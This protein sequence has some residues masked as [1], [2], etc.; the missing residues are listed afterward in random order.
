MTAA[1]ANRLWQAAC[2]PAE[3]AFRR[4]LADP[5]AAQTAVLHAHVRTCAATEIGR[6][7]GLGRVRTLADFRARVPLA[8]WED[9]APDA[10]RIAQGAAGVW[11]PGRPER[12]E[13]TSGTAGGTK[14]V[15]HTAAM[16]SQVRAA[17][18]AWMADLF[19]AY[20]DLRDGPAYWSVSPA[21]PLPP[22]RAGGPPV[23]FDGDADA[24]SPVHA[25]LARAALAVPDALRHA[26]DPDAHRTATL[27]AL[28]ART[29]LRLVSVWNPTALSLLLAPLRA[30]AERLAEDLARGTLTADVP[31]AVRAAVLRGVRPDPRRAHALRAAARETADAGALVARL[32]PRLG[33]VSAWADAHAAG[34]FAA[35][36]AL[37][38]QATLQPKG[39][40]ATEGVVSIPRVGH[41]GAALALTSHV[42][43]LLDGGR[44]VPLA[45]ADVGG[46]FEVALTTGAGLLRYRLGDTVEVVGRLGRCPLV[47]FVGRAGLVSDRVGEK[48]AEA[49]VAA[50]LARLGLT[51][52]LVACD[53]A[54]RPPAYVL[55]AETAAPDA[56]LARDA[57]RLDAALGANVHYA[58][59]RRLGQLGAVRAFR[60]RGSGAEQFVAGCV[61]L[62]QRA[63]SVKPAAL[64]RDGGWTARFSGGFV[65]GSMP[66]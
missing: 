29:G 35:L 46:R 2:A 49:H 47:R 8:T 3:R 52:A 34:P 5:E 11:T 4:A 64:H 16:R 30:D 13:P 32:W 57:G 6:R 43:E 63:G 19:Q 53:D 54:A 28:V 62:G 58:H 36:G 42:V 51:F 15:P 44:S 55:F 50:C 27:R 21:V 23:G 1:L 14:L 31:E 25:H 17:I 39:L 7:T 9:L 18:G 24:L 59:A 37:A 12:L 41:D 65:C 40:L 10:E 33:L 66:A 56:A 26:L 38:P 60:V 61:A 22:A 20:P 48:L 45:Q